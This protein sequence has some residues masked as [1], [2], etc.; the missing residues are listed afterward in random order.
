MS[1]SQWALK[2]GVPVATVAIAI[3]GLSQS[4]FVW[5][6]THIT[7][8]DRLQ[9]NTYVDRGSDAQIKD[10]MKQVASISVEQLLEN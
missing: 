10:G 8:I 2:V 1:P 4:V 7:Y 9:N 6:W 3:I 5:K